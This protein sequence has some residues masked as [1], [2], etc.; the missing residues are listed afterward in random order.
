MQRDEKMKNKAI[1]GTCKRCGHEVFYDKG[2]KIWVHDNYVYDNMARCRICITEG[3][4]CRCVKEVE[5]ND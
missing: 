3:K 4:Y 2:R 5:K 1:T